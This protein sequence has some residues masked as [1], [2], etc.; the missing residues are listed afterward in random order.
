MTRWY[1]LQLY[2]PV[3]D[4]SNPAEA[5]KMAKI[6]FELSEKV[7]TSRVDEKRD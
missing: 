6:A 1:G 3:L 7:E 2:I 4:P 5:Y